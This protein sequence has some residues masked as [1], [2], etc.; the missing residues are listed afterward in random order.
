[1]LLSIVIP[2]Y[3]EAESLAALLAR[4][5]AV[6]GSL[7]CEYELVF[8][9][10]GSTDA[11]G[12]LLLDAAARDARLKL[13]E[14]SRNFGHQTA[15]TAGLDFA[16]GD[17]VVVM[18]A[19]LQDPPELLPEMLRLFRLGYDVVS[20]QRQDRP[21][22][23]RFKRGTAGLFYWIMRRFVDP[24]LRAEVG[25]F[26]L[27]SRPAVLA[28]RKFRE[29]HRFMRGLVAWLGLKEVIVP[30]RREERLAG[31]TKYPLTKMLRFA[32][33]AI[34]SFSALP[35]RLGAAA[36]LLTTLFGICYFLYT[37]FIAIVEKTA[38]P[39]WTSLV[40]LQ[41]IFS[42]SILTAVGLVGDYVARI[43]EEAKGRPLYVVGRTANVALDG[44]GPTRGVVLDPSAPQQAA[45][46]LRVGTGK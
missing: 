20:A 35:L 14:F 13:L 1:M 44:A 43:Y 31:T 27:F 9:N 6:L 2:V 46:A 33:T 5:D 34:S 36:G 40:C 45:R 41:I 29:Q 30:F 22:D 3:N 23:S 16:G 24:R 39:G 18:D 7:D 25:D 37:L 11:T 4:L 19:D 8:V 42:G 21:G 32:W 12:S 28:V 10:D 17:A 15:I 26:R 38:I